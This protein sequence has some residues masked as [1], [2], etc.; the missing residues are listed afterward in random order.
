MEDGTQFCLYDAC[1]GCTSIGNPI[2]FLIPSAHRCLQLRAQPGSTSGETG[3]AACDCSHA[4][5]KSRPMCLQLKLT[6]S[7]SVNANGKRVN[8]GLLI[9]LSFAPLKTLVRGRPS[10]SFGSF[11][12]AGFW[13][14]NRIWRKMICFTQQNRR[15]SFTKGQDQSSRF[16]FFV[17]VVHHATFVLQLVG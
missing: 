5:I 1:R 8:I 10:G 16:P 4:R 3:Y 15:I 11:R 7:T 6:I 12:E 13:F 2:F 9:C 14:I 17:F